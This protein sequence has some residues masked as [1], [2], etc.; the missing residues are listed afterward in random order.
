MLKKHSRLFIIR[1][2]IISPKLLTPCNDDHGPLKVFGDMVRPTFFSV[3]NVEAVFALGITCGHREEGLWF[4]CIASHAWI[5]YFHIH[6]EKS[7]C[8]WGLVITRSFCRMQPSLAY[9][10]KPEIWDKAPSLGFSLSPNGYHLL[11][12][13]PARSGYYGT[14]L[15]THDSYILWPKDMNCFHHTL[16]VEVSLLFF[17]F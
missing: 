10:E 4:R 9:L 11:F 16:S 7:S 17:L 1:F 3:I 13:W 14:E 8:I 6:A 2:R 12:F 15:C 5:S